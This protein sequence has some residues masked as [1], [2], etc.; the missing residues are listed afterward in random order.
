MVLKYFLLNTDK[1]ICEKKEGN[2][3]MVSF[4]QHQ[5]N[6]HLIFLLTTH[7]NITILLSTSYF[8]SSSTYMYNIWK[9]KTCVVSKQVAH[10][11]TIAHMSPSMPRS[12]MRFWLPWQPEFL[13]NLPKNLMQPPFNTDA[14]YKIG[15]LALKISCLK[16]WV[17]KDMTESG[18][19]VSS[20]YVPLAQEN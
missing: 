10:K 11:A 12:N 13:S 8:Q 18:N 14:T 2:D 3:N 20:P 6:L 5:L 7:L 4:L 15:Q 16:M 1:L 17:T 9:W 19:T